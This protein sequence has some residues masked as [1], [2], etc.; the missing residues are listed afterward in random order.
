MRVSRIYTRQ[1]LNSGATVTLG[2]ELSHYVLRV[3][4]LRRGDPLI[5]FNGDGSEYQAILSEADRS[6]AAAL[7][8]QAD[9]PHRESALRVFLGQGLARGERMDFVLQKS[10]ELGAVS[11]TPLWT[12]RCQVQLSGKRLENRLAHWHGIVRSAC[13]QSNRVVLPGLDKPTP[14]PEWLA[15]VQLQEQQLKLVLDPSATRR[16]RDLP[17][18]SSVSILV[19]P[20]GGLDE[21]EIRLS[22][23]NGFQRIRMGPRVLRTETA[24]L[25]ALAAVQTLW[26]DL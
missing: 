4:R 22:E 19:G 18:A 26:G 14:L 25:A 3:L 20:E 11:I 8:G 24:A 21:D 12:N 6:Q 7:I 9:K 17:P 13:E 23:S 1:L 15:A 5:L 10:A 16:L 2:E